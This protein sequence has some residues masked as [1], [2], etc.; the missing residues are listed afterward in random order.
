MSSFY[1]ATEYLYS[2]NTVK[3]TWD[4][5]P[6][7]ILFSYQNELMQRY[8]YIIVEN[9]GTTKVNGTYYPVGIQNEAFVWE[10]QNHIYLTR[11][12][13]DNKFGWVFGNLR[14]CF[15]GCQTDKQFPSSSSNWKCYN[16]IDPSPHLRSF[17]A[18]DY[19]HLSQL[20]NDLKSSKQSLHWSSS[21]LQKY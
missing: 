18:G 12:K 1:E 15:Y 9:C 11:E 21:F 20:Q 6:H 19:Y 10:N 13:I 14:D 7:P 3:P 16:G 2:V 5:F 8:S 4:P 17:I